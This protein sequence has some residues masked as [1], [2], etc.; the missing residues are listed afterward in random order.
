MEHRLSLSTLARDLHS[1]GRL[2]DQEFARVMAAQS[3]KVHPLVYLAEQK[4]EDAAAPGKMLDMDGLLAWLGARVGQPVYQIDPLKINVTA[5][6][7][8]MSRA[9]AE[10]HRILAVAVSAEEVVVASGEP[11]ISSWESNLEH[12]LRKRV[13]RV[14]TDPRATA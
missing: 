14:L 4:I 9:F 7:E 10:R 2:S 12:V 11:F 1:E 6:A 8:V 5:V 3:V 13:R